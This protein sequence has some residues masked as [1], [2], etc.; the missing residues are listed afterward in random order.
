[1]GMTGE[2]CEYIQGEWRTYERR[3]ISRDIASPS[4][5]SIFSVGYR[6]VQ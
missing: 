5:L 3:R 4:G 1:M 2:A 6:E